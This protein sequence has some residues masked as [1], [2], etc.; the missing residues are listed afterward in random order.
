MFERR[1]RIIRDGSTLSFDY[2]P[3]KVLGRE[4]QMSQLENLFSPLAIDGKSCTAFLYGGV[5]AGKTVTARRFCLDLDTY[6]R[7]N[8]KRLGTVYV[9]CR[10]KSS[11]YSVTLDILRHFDP[12]FPERGFALDEIMALI[13]KGIENRMEPL[14]VVLDEVD[15]MLKGTGKN[16]IYQLT[17]MPEELKAGSLSLIL[18]SQYSLALMLDEATMSTFR[19]SNM[20]S[21]AG[22]TKEELETIIR[23]RA[24]IAF[25]DGV[26][27]D[28]SVDVLASAAEEFNDARFAIE[29][30]ER[31][32]HIAESMGEK[33]ITPDCVREASSSSYS[34]LSEEKLRDLDLNRKI[35]LLSIARAIKSLSFVSITKCEKTYAVVCEE[36]NVPVKK[37]TQYYT[38]VQDMEKR[39]LVR[40]EV[41][42]D[43]DGGRVT[44]ISIDNIPPKELANKLEYLLE[45]DRKEEVDLE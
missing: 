38:Y 18:I 2:V 34:D 33:E 3:E 6:F 11:E 24:G 8:G 40:T 27:P 23:Y 14:V 31:A 15:V 22:Y 1:S 28:E 43:T 32:A 4:K 37:H 20:I 9:N 45:K 44:F 10:I 19:R 30:M 39:G 16:L 36:Y 41:R 42:R 12:G 7:Q 26:F 21:F 17:R 25:Y 29:V 35:V 13:K 5:G